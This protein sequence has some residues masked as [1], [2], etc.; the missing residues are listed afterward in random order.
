MVSWSG[1]RLHRFEDGAWLSFGAAPGWTTMSIFDVSF[2][3]DGRRALVV[4]QA[5]GS[6]LRAP[7]LE[8]RHDLYSFA[9]ITDVSIAGFASA[10]YLG[11]TSTSL[12]DSAF[13][14]GCDGGILVGGA[15]SAGTGL[16][17]EFQIEGG[18]TCR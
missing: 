5:G 9:A 10:S 3:G 11:T 2:S 6:P 8:Y 4:G 15:A 1:R 7:V 12:N 14:P 13:R 18:V 16:F 17:I